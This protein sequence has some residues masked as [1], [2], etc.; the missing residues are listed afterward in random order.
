M[1]RYKSPSE[2]A[3][4]LTLGRL[5]NFAREIGAIGPV[6]SEVCS[7]SIPIHAVLYSAVYFYKIGLL[8]IT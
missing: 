7:P 2:H 4:C 8:R 3:W 6:R 5:V 1:N